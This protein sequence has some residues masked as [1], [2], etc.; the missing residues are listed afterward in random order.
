MFDS[1]AESLGGISTIK[2][3]HL[4]F[5]DTLALGLWRR[6]LSKPKLD[7][8]AVEWYPRDAKYVSRLKLWSFC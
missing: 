3:L 7:K 1:I 5:Y 4:V 6:H 8:F 2:S